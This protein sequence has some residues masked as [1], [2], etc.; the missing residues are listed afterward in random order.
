[1]TIFEKA[2]AV[3]G[4]SL[5]KKFAKTLEVKAIENTFLKK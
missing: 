1:M 4:E 3:Y 5:Q 2:I